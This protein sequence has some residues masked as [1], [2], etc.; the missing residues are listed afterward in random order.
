MPVPS[1]P[2]APKDAPIPAP[3]VK[4]KTAKADE[5]N[6]A[7]YQ[8]MFQFEQ[9]D[10]RPVKS[11]TPEPVTAE[12]SPAT[13]E[14]PLTVT[15]RKAVISRPVET[16]SQPKA[17]TQP[18]LLIELPMP[19]EPR[20]ST[21]STLQTPEIEGIEKEI[22]K[23]PFFD[24]KIKPISDI[25]PF[26][27]YEPD[28]SLREADPT[29]HF[30]PR[31][32]YAHLMP[33]SSNS[34]CPEISELPGDRVSNS[35]QFAHL[36]YCWVASNI[37]YYPLYFEDPQ[38]ERY[39]HMHHPLIQPFVSV[40]RF[41]WQFLGLPYQISMNPVAK[42]VYP[43][44]YFRPGD[45]EAPKLYHQVPLNFHAMFITAEVYTGLF[46]LFP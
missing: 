41:N 9:K 17:A 33:S 31:P 36:Q 32:E 46:F 6:V 7:I 18:E 23:S 20:Y 5:D 10:A 44:G 21:V 19:V 12:R 14:K 1:A 35:R 3:P 28:A 11:V 43:L 45:C 38:L 27:T 15:T 26:V 13:E 37:N 25:S 2:A 29:R 8:E 34:K 42:C 30:C 4:E 16:P 39:G 22:D 40:S 24:E